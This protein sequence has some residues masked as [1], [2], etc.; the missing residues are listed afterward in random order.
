M[1]YIIYLSWLF[2]A[3]EFT[4]M[5]LKRSKKDTSKQRNDRGSLIL[6]WVMITVSFILG[7][8]FANYHLW[9][10]SNYIIAG[11]GLLIMLLGFVIRWIS[12][13]QLKNAFTVDV[14]IGNE[15]DLKT[16]GMYKFV[17][18]PSYLGLLLIMAGFGICMNS[19]ISFIVMVVLMIVVL[20]YR[21][22]VEEK[23]LVEEFDDS[24]KVYKTKTK[25]LIP[26]VF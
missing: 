26:W 11:L 15:Q 16:N 18:H 12:I 17:R 25:K 22:Y 14:A 19:I 6:L 4:L 10:S 24:Y 13:L 1:E 8:I 23:A 5:I 20:L 21:I 3:S 7:F 2:F 9:R